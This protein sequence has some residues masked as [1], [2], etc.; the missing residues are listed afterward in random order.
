MRARLLR[1]GYLLLGAAFVLLRLLQVSPWDQSVD[2]YAYWSTR[3]GE[4]Y[5][6]ATGGM[7]SYLYSP[8]FAQLLAPVVIVPWP[9][10]A[11][12]WTVMNLALLSWLAGPWSLPLLLVPPVSFEIVSGNVHLLIAAAIVLGFRY[13]ATW[14]ATILTKLTPGVGLLWF[15]VRREWRSLSMALGATVAI[16]GV[17]FVL[18][19][20][21]W[22]DWVG[23][24][25]RDLGTPLVTL[26]WFIPVPLLVRLPIAAAVVVWGGRT[27]RAWTIPLA[28]T[29][30]MPVIWL[31]SLAVL[32]A[33]IPLVKG[34][35]SAATGTEGD[36]QPTV[37]AHAET[38]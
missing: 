16:A 7:G 6:G 34:V 25:T 31:N 2:A 8:A 1:D 30:A 38:A 28:V 37:A 9:L 21:A 10:F 35:S 17:S 5:S 29:L 36:R 3:D 14:A 12:L 20:G 22:F 11:A 23:V 24:L 19:R 33:I 13:P 32:V 4:F 26:G 27:S 18:D 15:V